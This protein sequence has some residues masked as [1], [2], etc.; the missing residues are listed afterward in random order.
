[1]DNPTLIQ[2]RLICDLDE[3]AHEPTPMGR[4][5]GSLFL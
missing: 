1:M 2:R 3:G 4:A 5:F